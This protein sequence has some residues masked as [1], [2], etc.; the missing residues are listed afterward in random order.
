MEVITN[1]IFT[2]IHGFEEKY[3]V[4]RLQAKEKDKYEN[5]LSRTSLVQEEWKDKLLAMYCQSATIIYLLFY[6]EMVSLDMFEPLYTYYNI[7]LNNQIYKDTKLNLLLNSLVKNNNNEIINCIGHFYQLVRDNGYKR[8]YLEY[9]FFQ[10]ILQQK[11]ITFTRVENKRPNNTIYYAKGKELTLISSTDSKEM[12]IKQVFDKKKSV[13]PFFNVID[14]ASYKKTKVYYYAEVVRMIQTK[15]SDIITIESIKEMFNIKKWE[16][17]KKTYI[18]IQKLLNQIGI[19]IVNS[20]DN[21]ECIKYLKYILIHAFDKGNIDQSNI[22]VGNTFRKECINIQIVYEKKEYVENNMRDAYKKSDVFAIQHIYLN[23]LI[24]EYEKL[25]KKE[26]KKKRSNISERIIFDG[27]IKYEIINKDFSLA[28]IERVTIPF[29]WKYY[30]YI[31]DEKKEKH[32]FMLEF[33]ENKPFYKEIK[34]PIV[35]GHFKDLQSIQYAIEKEDGQFMYIEENLNYHP[36]PDFTIVEKRLKECNEFGLIDKEIVINVLN[37]FRDANINKFED[38]YSKIFNDK[39]SIYIENIH[40]IDDKYINR[41]TILHALKPDRK[42]PYIGRDFKQYFYEV[43]GKRIDAELSKPDV[44]EQY[45]RGYIHVNYKLEKNDFYYTVGK[46]KENDF[47]NR[48]STSN[49]I[50][51]IKNCKY[52]DFEKYISMLCVDFI[53]VNQMT[54]IPFIFKYL[55]EYAKMTNYILKI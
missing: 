19:H 32:I 41:K 44:I 3:D 45:M 49:R 47:H 43:T 9:R 17:P 14:L 24:S 38:N 54:S 36:L 35:L 2:S 48:L 15:L 30:I 23:N 29:D 37:M 25:I 46:I 33:I 55:R 7:T 42:K 20:T 6:K 39:I 5:L 40:N 18:S 31:C 12:Y 1:K 22:S 50:R 26:T 10:G 13:V 8:I 34:N 16:K 52:E 11:V 4:I 27:L 53:R 28:N 51:K 21:K